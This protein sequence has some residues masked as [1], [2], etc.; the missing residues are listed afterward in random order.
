[1]G[2]GKPK[3]GEN[4]WEGGIDVTTFHT[5]NFTASTN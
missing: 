5:I 1:M 2:I 3:R 4:K